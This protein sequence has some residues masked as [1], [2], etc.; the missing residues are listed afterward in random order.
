M[1][2][3]GKKIPEYVPASFIYV[4]ITKHTDVVLNAFCVKH[5]VLVY[6]VSNFSRKSLI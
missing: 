5:M 2:K 1:T 6:S 3:K 4:N